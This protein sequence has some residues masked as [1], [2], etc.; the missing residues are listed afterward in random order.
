MNSEQLRPVF[1]R[2][3]DYVQHL[4]RDFDVQSG[5]RVSGAYRVELLSF[6]EFSRLWD[7]WGESNGEQEIWQRRFD[8]GYD[9]FASRLTSRLTDAL[10]HGEQNSAARAA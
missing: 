7:R 4:Q 6:E 1:E 9:R 5:T 2:Y 3:V 10:T 8:E